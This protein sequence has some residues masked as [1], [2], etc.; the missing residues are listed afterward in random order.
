[1]AGF[2]FCELAPYQLDTHFGAVSNVAL[3]MNRASWAKQP[4]A[5]QAALKSSASAWAAANDKK[6]K[7]GAKAGKALCE[8]TYKQKT[9]AL[10]PAEMK[11]WA[12]ALPPMGKNWAK[13]QDDAGMPGTKILTA[14]MD[15]M[16]DKKQ[17]VL[18]DWDKQ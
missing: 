5:V 18:R 15:Y 3:T 9:T 13:Q 16:R 4:A 14:W 11:T 12:M 2:K 6:L 8:N 7:D 17:P 1:M 10:T